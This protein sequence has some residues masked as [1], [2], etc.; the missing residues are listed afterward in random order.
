ML[1]PDARR[2]ILN[3]LFICLPTLLLGTLLHRLIEPTGSNRAIAFQP[4][5]RS[6]LVSY[7]T[8]AE[9]AYLAH[10]DIWEVDRVQKTV[11][12]GGDEALHEHLS[13]AGYRSTIDLIPISQQ[14]HADLFFDGY[15][16]KTE[17]YNSIDQIVANYPALVTLYSYGESYCAT[18]GGCLL[19]TGE[20]I[21][22]SDL[23]ALRLTNPA[24]G[25]PSSIS[26][27]GVL[28]GTKPIFLFMSALHAREISTPELN[29]R[30]AEWLLSNYGQADS[31]ATWLLDH[32]E[33]WLIP[34]A[35]PDG[36]EVV[37]LGESQVNFPYYQR[38]NLNPTGCGQWPPQS[39]R[40]FGVDLNRNHSFGW[41][42][43]GASPVPCDAT[44]RG[45]A[46]ASE[47]EI[48]SLEQ[49]IRQLFADQRGPNRTDIAPDD[50]SGLVIT[51]HSYGELILW[52]WG[53]GGSPAT[54]PNVA[55]LSALG[56]KMASYNGY[57]AG[58]A[59][60]LYP[61]AGATDDFVYGELGVP[62][63]TFE[64]GQSFF[65]DFNTLDTEQW[66][67]NR[68]ALLYAAKVAG[69]PYT[70]V[71]GPEGT[72]ITG[73]IS[74]NI[75]TVT[76]TLSDVDTGNEAI[77]A[78]ELSLNDPH[79]VSGTVTIPLQP[80]DGTFDSPTETVFV[81]TEL[82]DSALY[83]Q[84]QATLSLFVRGRDV[85]GNWGQITAGVA[86]PQTL[87][88]REHVGFLPIIGTMSLPNPD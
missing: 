25:Q 43:L 84:N 64:V 1:K 59:T 78:A 76:G 61:A 12:I 53:D 24:V 2:Y 47:P 87:P 80:A 48:A 67:P 82:P 52:P 4:Q 66:E 79:W 8:E 18:S 38:K 57:F 49:L 46:A 56:N 30:F 73:H 14:R 62:S 21:A 72:D 23:L 3:L 32:H 71:K 68:P 88:P 29:L 28:S 10:Y 36:Y 11:R 40:Q 19:P 9:L 27:S 69:A 81:E 42:G 34:L 58:Q 31:D 86:T 33:I 35:N 51:M 77:A 22:G 74:G 83:K 37:A 17:L 13:R 50:T 63:F 16:T 39:G 45:T 65:P 54:A 5:T 60:S 55:G 20:T 26:N 41:G 75:L 15:R 6:L 44:Y 7:K 70:L 85:S